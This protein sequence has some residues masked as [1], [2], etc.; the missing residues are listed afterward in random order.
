MLHLVGPVAANVGRHE[1]ANKDMLCL[2]R[3]IYGYSTLPLL[4]SLLLPAS[5][6]SGA[7]AVGSREVSFQSAGF[8]LVGTLTN[9]IGQPAVADVLIIPGSGP[10]DRDG[11]ARI[12][13][14]WC[15]RIGSG[16][17]G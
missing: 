7:L 11:L 5:Q 13:P 2:G 14:G 10:V 12:V 3:V 6:S 4:L 17:S 8:R 1:T 15:R 16:R 9:P